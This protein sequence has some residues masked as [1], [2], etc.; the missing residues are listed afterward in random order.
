MHA[1]ASTVQIHMHAVVTFVILYTLPCKQDM[2]ELVQLWQ[3]FFDLL[4]VPFFSL[5]PFWHSFAETESSAAR[6]PLPFTVNK[7]H[8]NN[9]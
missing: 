1:V 4:L 9:T 5:L 6:E 3:Q 2:C 8:A 7:H